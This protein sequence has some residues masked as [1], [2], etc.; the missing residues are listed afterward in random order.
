VPNVFPQH[1]G[2]AEWFAKWLDGRLYQPWLMED[3][4]TGQWRGATDAEHE[5]ALAQVRADEL[6]A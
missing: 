1:V 2:V 5:A 4:S 6:D 3:P